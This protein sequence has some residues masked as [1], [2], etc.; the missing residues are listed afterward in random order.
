MGLVLTVDQT[1]KILSKEWISEPTFDADGNIIVDEN[2]KPVM[3][4]AP[5]GMLD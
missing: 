4:S 1:G 5:E 3:D 2:G